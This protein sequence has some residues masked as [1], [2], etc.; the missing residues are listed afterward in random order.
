M[1]EL[2]LRWY[3]GIIGATQ[4][5]LGGVVPFGIDMCKQHMLGWQHNLFAMDEQRLALLQRQVLTDGRMA[6]FGPAT[7]ISDGKTLSS[8]WATRLLGME[9]ELGDKRA[10]HRVIVLGPRPIAQALPAS[11]TAAGGRDRAPR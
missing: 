2:F 4:E 5:A 9:M 1:R 6:I 3:R 10:L 11:L 7:G 8:E